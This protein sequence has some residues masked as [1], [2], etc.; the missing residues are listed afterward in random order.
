M[1][2]K[3]PSETK[4]EV[5]TP[6]VVPAAIPA[7]DDGT[8]LFSQREKDILAETEKRGV[9]PISPTLA[10]QFFELFLEGY[11]CQQIAK[12]NPHFSEGDILFLRKKRNWDSDRDHYAYNLQVQIREKLIKQRLESLEFL[13]NMLSVTHKE[14]KEKVLRYLQ[15]GKEEDRPENWITGPSAYKGILEAI[16][17]LTGEDRVTTQNIKSES[18]V[19]VESNVPV[20]VISPELQTKM[21]KKLSEKPQIEAKIGKKENE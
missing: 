5:K 13:T 17:K 20:T 3:S 15:T 16:Q 8:S 9:K 7:A 11:S 12:Q 21:L 18:K 19:T 14:H 6:E 2:Q 4:E 10:A 1:D